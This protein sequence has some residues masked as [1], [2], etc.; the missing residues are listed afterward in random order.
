V[1]WR[2]LGYGLWVV[3]LVWG[4]LLIGFHIRQSEIPPPRVLT[5]QE[6]VNG[7]AVSTVAPPLTRGPGMPLDGRPAPWVRARNLAGR[8]VQ[9]SA[10]RGRVVVLTFVNP[11]CGVDCSSLIPVIEGA[12]AEAGRPGQLALVAVSVNPTAGLPAAR[13]WWAGLNGRVQGTVVVGP[14]TALTRLWRLYGVTV[15]GSGNGL[16]YTPALYIMNRNGREDVLFIVQ[17]GLVATQARTLAE[18][19][20]RAL[21]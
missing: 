6:V 16:A 9:L 2:R 8:S 21:G 15:E 17:Q 19:I 14:K 7:F 1:T 10:W 4:A 20:R 3:V 11:L 13:H 5:V 12:W 18:A